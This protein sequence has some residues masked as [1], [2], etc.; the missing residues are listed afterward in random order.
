MSLRVELLSGAD[1]DL[2]EIFNRYEDYRENFGVEFMVAMDAY[3]TRIS[4]FPGIAPLYFENVRRQVMQE[5]PYGIFYEEQA[6]RILV[7]AILDLR[8]DT[9]R[10]L[11]RLR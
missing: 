5:F 1:A 7:L 8:Q 2:Q 11:S 9:E 10:I 6:A 4:T 3:L